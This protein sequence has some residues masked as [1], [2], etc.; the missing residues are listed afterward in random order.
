MSELLSGNNLRGLMAELI[1][2]FTFVFMGI[3]A[4]GAAIGA[5]LSLAEPFDTA[6]LIVISLG[7]GVGIFVGIIVFGRV[8]GAHINPAV[9]IAAI[10][11]GNIG[12]IRGVSYIV[13]QLIGATIAAILIEQ[14]AWPIANLGVH[15]PSIAVG[16]ALVI[17]VIVSFFLVFTIFA[18]AIDKRGNAMWAPLAIALVVFV[19]HLIA[20]P[21]T[22]ASM[23][24]AR[25]FG[26]AL[27]GGY[28]TDHWI[29]WAGPIVGGIAAAIAYV[30]IF[31]EKADR[32]K[33]GTL[34]LGSE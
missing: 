16:D 13:G 6:G 7:H 25:S 14:F 5:G 23:N 9:T 19:D 33:F 17:E 22:G 12:I 26:P 11:S 2:T 18:T 24:P 27:A 29:Y 30:M 28:W 32:D 3:G 20:V 31:G 15:G 4:I 21:L 10:I 1:A 34:S 8:T